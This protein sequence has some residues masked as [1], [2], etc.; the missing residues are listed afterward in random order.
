MEIKSTF[1]K[2]LRVKTINTEKTLTKQNLADQ[3]N[4]N[5]IIRRYAKTGTLPNLN[6]LE[7]IYGEITSQ[8]LQ[9]AHEMIASASEAF[10]Q[11]PSEIRKQF[12]NDAGLFIDYAT[13]PQNIQQMASWN[14]AKLPDKYYNT[15]GST[16]TD[17]NINTGI[18][19]GE[20]K[21]EPQPIPTT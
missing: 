19:S 12:N 21:T 3:A 18:E 6:N 7:A 2:K 9:E 11:I 13:N 5:N 10:D 4:V 15:D 16:N 17:N 14:L 20:A 1:S 8:G